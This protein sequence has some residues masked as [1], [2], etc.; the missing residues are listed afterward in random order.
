MYFSSVTASFFLSS[1]T[2]M[3]G[4]TTVAATYSE[5]YIPDP[6]SPV[7]DDITDDASLLKY[8][9]DSTGVPQV[10]AMI[11]VPPTDRNALAALRYMRSTISAEPVGLAVS[12]KHWRA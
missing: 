11:P 10:H 2:S 9:S 1:A 7:N 5:S 6:G 12:E 4:S 3:P 8:D